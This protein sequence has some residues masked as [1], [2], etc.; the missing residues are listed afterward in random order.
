M[1]TG[2]PPFGGADE[3]LHRTE[4]LRAHVERA[5][6]P[7]RTSRPR[8]LVKNVQGLRRLP[9]GGQSDPRVGTTGR[10]LAA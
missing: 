6:T 8:T 7:R 5:P 1:L 9:G 2:R 3:H 10:R 4:I